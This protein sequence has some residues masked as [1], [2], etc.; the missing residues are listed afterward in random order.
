[1]AQVLVVD[2]SATVRN[3][4]SDFLTKNGFPNTTA[5]DGRDGL[6]KLKADKDIRLVISDVNMPNMDGLTMVEKIR[7]ELGNKSVNIIMLT[8]ESD[9][10]MKARGKSAGVK[11]W[12]VKPFKG[13]GLVGNLKKLVG[14]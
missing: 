1:M 5:N 10:R 13:D 8:T 4:V 11:G 7:G 9:S 12:I 14:S 2:D 6:E 3:E